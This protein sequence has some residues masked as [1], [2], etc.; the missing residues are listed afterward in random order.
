VRAGREGANLAAAS[1]QT[2]RWAC[3][4][5]L[6]AGS[7]VPRRSWADTHFDQGGGGFGGRRPLAC[8][9]RGRGARSLGTGTAAQGR[10]PLPRHQVRSWGVAISFHRS[11]W[12]RCAGRNCCVWMPQAKP[13]GRPVGSPSEQKRG[14]PR[15]PPAATATR[16]CPCGVPPART[17]TS[18]RPR[19][20]R[21]L[22]RSAGTLT[23]T[24]HLTGRPPCV[25]WAF[26]ARE[27]ACAWGAAV[28]G[29]SLS[30]C[31]QRVRWRLACVLPEAHSS[32]HDR[33]RSRRCVGAGGRRELLAGPRRGSL[34]LKVAGCR[35]VMQRRVTTRA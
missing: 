7:V 35:A 25:R 2:P 22:R 3:K 20:L 21:C 14:A 29:S 1:Q 6:Q 19:P 8:S 27:H 26:R 33:V 24:T 10:R 12:P 31:L 28:V 30:A 32:S 34:P 9:C 13:P 16:C 23:S 11:I 15:T 18:P 5:S 17:A 4:M